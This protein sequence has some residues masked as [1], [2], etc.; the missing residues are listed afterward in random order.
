MK[1][2]GVSPG[3]VFGKAFVYIKNEIII[4]EELISEEL[5]EEEIKKFNN[6]IVKSKN[7]LNKLKEKTKSE[8]G[9]KESEIFQAHIMMLDDV[10]YTGKI[11]YE[12]EKNLYRSEKAVKVVSEEFIKLFEC[13]DDE[14]MRAR[15][16]DIKDIS[17]RIIKNILGIIDSDISNFDTEVIV[18]ANDLTPSD[19]AQMDKKNVLAFVAEIGGKT[20][21][22]AI[23]ARSLEIP[24]VLGFNDATKVISDGDYLIVDGLKGEVFV[25]PDNETIESYKIARSDYYKKIKE[26]NNIKSLE[27]ITS[28]GHKVEIA[29]NIGTPDDLQS[30]INNGGEGIGLYRTEFLY[31]NSDSMPDEDIQFKA[32]KDVLEK[33]N[34]NPVIIRTLDIGG[35]KNLEYLDMDKELNP[36]LG[37]RAIRLCFEKVEMFKTQ[38]RAILRASVYGNT[39]IMFPM[40]ANVGE[41]IK[42]KKLLNE[43]KEEL[44]I[45]GIKFNNNIKIGIMIE[46]PSAAMTADIIADEVDFFSIGT[47]DLCQYT[48]AADRMNEKVSYLYDHFDIGV[49]RLIKKVIDASH[50]KGIFTGM[51]G[52]MA[53]DIYASVILLGMGLDEFS[54]SASSIPKVKKLIREI[55]FKDAQELS[56]KVLMM[57]NS[58]EI[59]SYIK[60]RL[61]EL[62]IDVI[63]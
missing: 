7:Q 21:H 41:V 43:C 19:T 5:I 17:D 45:E 40:I 23:M 36:F 9:Q 59:K 44:K 24:A 20:S 39:H 27:A 33:M 37:L 4:S 63:E 16:D 61:K 31:M 52:E 11:K 8:V 12:I 48:L 38:L 22:T 32:Y 46:I 1:G 58:Q 26:L 60:Q 56:N 50:K 28:D 53:G 29:G 15:A 34:P 42:A 2:I 30:V 55:K 54:M 18:I 25:N 35:D 51:C 49:L 6:A 62:K 57:K 14:Y 10:E 13:I 3:I 47:N